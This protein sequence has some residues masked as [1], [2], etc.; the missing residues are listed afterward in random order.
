MHGEV[1][2]GE[3]L[4]TI[5]EPTRPVGY[6]R[7]VVRLPLVLSHTSTLIGFVFVFLP[8]W[9]RSVLRRQLQINPQ[10]LS[11]LGKIHFIAVDFESA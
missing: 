7:T 11:F 5:L 3:V 1:R 6:T 10:D 9:G 8:P 2:I 4:S